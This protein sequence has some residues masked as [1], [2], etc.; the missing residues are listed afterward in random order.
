MY[1]I[2]F[3]YDAWITYSIP[4]LQYT[5]L[6]WKKA[7]VQRR[8][9]IFPELQLGAINSF[10]GFTTILTCSVWI[11]HQIKNAGTKP[12]LLRQ[13][14]QNFEITLEATISFIVWLFFPE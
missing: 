3:D 4:L 11:P 5:K 1:G 2:L 14:R 13:L 10:Y 7:C 9:L 8:G 6:R 12:H